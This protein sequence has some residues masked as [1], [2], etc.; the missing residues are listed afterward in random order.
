MN[1][2][3]RLCRCRT[4]EI[5]HNLICLQRLATPVPGYMTEQA[6]L[7][8]VPFA[9]ARRKVAHLDLQ[10]V[11]VAQCLQFRLPQAV[12]TTVT[13]ATVGRDQQA[14]RLR[15]TAPAQTFPP[16]PDR[17]HRELG[18]VAADAHTDPRLVVRQIVDAVRNRLPF[19]RIGEVVN[20][21]FARLSSGP[22]LLPW[23]L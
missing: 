3:P 12:S 9:R 16:G 7:D 20:I 19:T 8:L 2:E 23:I 18:G 14:T 17:F 11:F 5:H 4:D 1:L 13:T 22:P 15:V 10:T 6:M 21:D